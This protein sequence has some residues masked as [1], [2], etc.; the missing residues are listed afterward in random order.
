MFYFLLFKYSI[1]HIQT[2]RLHAAVAICLL[3]HLTTFDRFSVPGQATDTSPIRNCSYL[4]TIYLL[5]KQA[6][7]FVISRVNC[8][9]FESQLKGKLGIMSDTPKKALFVCLGKIVV[10]SETA[11]PTSPTINCIHFTKL[12]PFAPTYRQHMS[13]TDR[14]S[15]FH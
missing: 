14:R 9:F 15:S 2:N 7:L 5:L 1:L 3:G 12:N 11:V 13:F 4:T 10:H 8:Q 6:Q